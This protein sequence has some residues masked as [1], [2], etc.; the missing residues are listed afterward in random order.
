V[1]LRVVWCPRALDFWD[2][3]L[4]LRQKQTVTAP[5][6]AYAE[7]EAGRVFWDPPYDRVPCGPHHEAAIRVDREEGVLYVIELYR[8]PVGRV[9]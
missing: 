2:R 1:S 4:S 9:G 5:I 3:R 7:R 8:R 6:Y